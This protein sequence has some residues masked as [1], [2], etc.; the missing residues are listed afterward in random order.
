MRRLRGLTVYRMHQYEIWASTDH[1]E[2]RNVC[3]LYLFGLASFLRIFAYE[4]LE[5][6]MQTVTLPNSGQTDTKNKA[7][8]S[9]ENVANVKYLGTI[10][11][12]IEL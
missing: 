3:N 7:N 8:R 10:K 9:T 2:D 1:Q 4:F 11:I 5:L 6:E 12:K